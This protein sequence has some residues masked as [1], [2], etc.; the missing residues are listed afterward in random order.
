MAPTWRVSSLL[1]EVHGDRR[2]WK[3][4][5]LILPGRLAAPLERDGGD[6]A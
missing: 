4:E 2:A 5:R 6:A 1:P 3:A